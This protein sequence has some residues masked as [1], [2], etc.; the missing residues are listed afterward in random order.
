VRKTLDTVQQELEPVVFGTLALA[1]YRLEAAGTLPEDTA[2]APPYRRVEQ[3]ATADAP[4]TPPADRRRRRRRGKTDP[5]P[6]PPPLYIPGVKGLLRGL[7]EGLERNERLAM[8]AHGTRPTRTPAGRISSPEH[9]RRLG[10]DQPITIERLGV[11]VETLTNN[12]F[13]AL[14]VSTYI[15][16]HAPLPIII[17][18]IYFSFLIYILFSGPF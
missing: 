6:L 14:N 8:R 2:E 5:A 10:M 12:R 9:Q 15:V 3:A 17:I 18:V 16:V 7:E 13:H 4:A 11:L 1:L